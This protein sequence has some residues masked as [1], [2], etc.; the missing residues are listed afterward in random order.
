M[1]RDLY[2]LSFLD[3]EWSVRLAYIANAHAVNDIMQAA[4]DSPSMVAIQW[5][6]VTHIIYASV[7]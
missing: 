3:I 4:T 5:G 7:K 6:R 2:I 1:K